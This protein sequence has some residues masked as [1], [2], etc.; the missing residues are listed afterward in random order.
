MFLLSD[1]IHTEG[2]LIH[3]ETCMNNRPDLSFIL[4]AGFREVY[5][6]QLTARF[7]HVVA[8][9]EDLWD[10]P[11]A[12][13][14]YF[15]DLLVSKRPNRK[16]FPPEVGKEII[17]LSLAYERLRLITRPA[18]RL[19]PKVED[20]SER[21][22]KARERLRTLGI[23]NDLVSFARAV[24][25]CN[26]DLCAL[27]I[28]AGLDINMRDHRGLTM[29][30]VCA[31][32][33]KKEAADSLMRL[34]ADVNVRDSDGYTALHWASEGGN[35]SLVL[36]LLHKGAQVDPQSKA[37]VT[38][39]M[40]AASAGRYTTA[41]VLLEH[42]AC[43]NVTAETGATALY[44]AV[45]NGHLAVVEL[46]VAKGASVHSKLENGPSLIELS[47]RSEHPG[48]RE[49]IEHVQTNLWNTFDTKENRGTR[50][51]GHSILGLYP[52]PA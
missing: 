13:N 26:S 18:A 45:A 8:K 12:M 48:I 50:P 9:M 40:L 21:T 5:P 7:P 10:N 15:E 6:H 32:Q 2:S 43:P 46:L 30:I 28:E 47:K 23:E 20:L 22:R 38:P 31:M 29:L 4:D 3:L 52:K 44:R 36:S 17:R 16:G 35:T 34:G 1:M 14:A 24:S 25:A 37:G 27:M 42:G 51:A 41:E 49:L 11:Q 39:L 33:G 19:E